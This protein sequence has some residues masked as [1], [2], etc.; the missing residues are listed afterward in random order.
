LQP[1][2]SSVSVFSLPAQLKDFQAAFWALQR[3]R[4]S[5]RYERRFQ[6]AL[7]RF[8][9]NPSAL[10]RLQHLDSMKK[11]WSQHATRLVFTGDANGTSRTEGLNFQVKAGSMRRQLTLDATFEELFS[12]QTSIAAQIDMRRDRA[13]SSAPTH[14]SSG[15]DIFKLFCPW[16]RK[17]VRSACIYVVFLV[18]HCDLD[19]NRFDFLF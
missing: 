2:S 15:D 17:F 16:V 19:L 4:T 3:A 7:L 10:A 5:Q 1:S 18:N 8:D 9:R 6:A 12:L 13:T 11:T 14:L